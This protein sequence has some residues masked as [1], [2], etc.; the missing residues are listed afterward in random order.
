MNKTALIM[1]FTFIITLF[2]QAIA[3]E[4]VRVWESYFPD[5]DCSRNPCAKNVPSRALEAFLDKANYYHPEKLESKTWIF[6]ADF[7]Q[8]SR[9]K[10]GYL[11]NTKTGSSI[12]YHVA[13]GSGSGDGRGNTVRFSNVNNSKASSKGLYLTAE[14]YQGQNGYSLRMDGLE[15]TNSNARR[16]AIVIHGADYVSESYIRSNGRAGRSWGCPA[17]SNSVARDLI[18]KLRG[19][20]LY[21]IYGR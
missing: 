1:T 10:R 16:R 12:A 18:N 19:G 7:T 9:N 17:V 13:H 4:S 20:S 21:Y 14:T 15:H 8:P 11:I 3:N 2:N 6:L 5:V